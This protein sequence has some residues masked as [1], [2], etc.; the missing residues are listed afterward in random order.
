MDSGAQDDKPR[1]AAGPVQAFFEAHCQKCHGGDKLTA[2]FSTYR[3]QLDFA[4][5]SVQFLDGASGPIGSPLVLGSEALVTAL[6]RANNGTYANAVEWGVISL[7]GTVPS[8]ARSISVTIFETKTPE[9]T[10]IDGYVDNINLSIE[11]I[12]EPATV[13][14]SGLAGLL[15]LH[16]RRS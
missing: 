4:Q 13:A 9:G 16:R 3:H 14:L 8:L 7:A 1:A 10:A 12:P 2:Q 15:L 11:A 5:L 6:P